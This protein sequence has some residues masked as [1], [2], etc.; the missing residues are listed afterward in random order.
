VAKTKELKKR[1]WGVCQERIV[2]RPFWKPSPVRNWL[3]FQRAWNQHLA[4]KAHPGVCFEWSAAIR[5]SIIS[6]SKESFLWFARISIRLLRPMGALH[7]TLHCT[8]LGR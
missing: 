7:C 6:L 4:S 1:S 3:S 8:A 2:I 5:R